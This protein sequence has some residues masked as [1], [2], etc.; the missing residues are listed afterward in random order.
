MAGRLIQV[1]PDNVASQIAAGEVVERPASV[2]KELLENAF[3]AGASL[4]EVEIEG[5]G[6]TRLGVADNGAGMEEEDAALS[7]GRH[8]TSKIRDIADLNRIR[9][10]GFRGEALAAISS[11]ARVVLRTRSRSAAHGVELKLEG[12]KPVAVQA[13]A[14][15]PGTRLEVRDLFFNTPARL[16]FLKTRSTEQSACVEVVQRLALGNFTTAFRLRVDGREVLDLAPAAALAERFRA[17]YGRRL[18]EAMLSFEAGRPALRVFGLASQAHQSFPTSRM[19]LAYVNGRLVRDRMI[20][21][22]VAQAYQT[23]LP[24]GRHPAVVLMIELEPTE[25]DVN[26]HPTKSEVRFRRAGSVFEAVYHALRERLASS[27]AGAA[28][29]SGLPPGRPEETADAPQAQG[30]PAWQAAAGRETTASVQGAAAP[31]TAPANAAPLA[32]PSPVLR[33]AEPGSGPLR[34]VPFTAQPAALQQP[35]KLGF[36]RPV[37]GQQRGSAAGTS[38]EGPGPK[39]EGS[40]EAAVLSAGAA[41]PRSAAGASPAYCALRL[42]GQLFAG[43]IVLEEADG[44]VLVDQHAAHERVTF[45]R[46]SDQMKA[47]GVKVQRLLAPETIELN[48]ARAAVV[49]ASLPVFRLLG[50]EVEPFGGGALVLKG[51]PALFEAARACELLKDLIDSAGGAGFSRRG[52]AFVAEDWLKQLACH[53]AIRVGRILGAAEMR[54]LLADLEA[55]RFNTNCPHGRPVFVRFARAQVERLFRR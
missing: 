28:A 27:G 5:A 35:L 10:F 46:L 29:S 21:Q 14:M 4:V 19:T 55:T 51:A 22:A 8:A 53:G 9:T 16:A 44:F 7:F 31:E 2:L 18:A 52:E 47:E 43:Y 39:L 54:E 15:A 11:V 13:C 1:L 48:P 23:L 12:A 32:S 25:V 6:I 40:P 50:F 37:A 20:A 26:V 24:R 45:E 34:L 42:V 49:Q 38:D 33:G 36:G 30:V 17:L 41:R 3:D